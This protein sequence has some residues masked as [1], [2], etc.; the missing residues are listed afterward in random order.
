[1]RPGFFLMFVDQRNSM[2]K[3]PTATC[4]A[5]QMLKA[6]LKTYQDPKS[7]PST[8]PSCTFLQLL[9]TTTSALRTCLWLVWVCTCTPPAS[10]AALV[11]ILGRVCT[12]FTH[13]L[14]FSFA[15]G[16][17]RVVAAA[18]HAFIATDIAFLAVV[19]VGLT[20]RTRATPFYR[21]CSNRGVSWRVDGPTCVEARVGEV[22]HGWTGAFVFDEEARPGVRRRC[23]GEVLRRRSGPREMAFPWVRDGNTVPNRQGGNL[24]EPYESL[25]YVLPCL[26]LDTRCPLILLRPCGRVKG[27]TKGRNKTP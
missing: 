5:V 8:I 25:P 12:L 2:T 11:A 15:P 16:R 10:A 22:E 27:E 13:P 4:A 3:A 23:P 7:V 1:M 19:V 24:G 14:P 20:T 26:D 9:R 17:V 21:P 18:V 6:M